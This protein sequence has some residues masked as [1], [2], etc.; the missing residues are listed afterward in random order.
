MGL[1]NSAACASV[2]RLAVLHVP[3]P[4][5]QHKPFLRESYR[6]PVIALRV[7]QHFQD[8]CRHRL[9]RHGHQA[10]IKMPPG[11]RCALSHRDWEYVEPHL[12]RTQRQ[13]APRLI[14]S[15]CAPGKR[16][17]S[18]I[19]G[20][21][22]NL[23]QRPERSTANTFASTASKC[24]VKRPAPQPASKTSLPLRVIN[25]P[26]KR[27]FSRFLKAEVPLKESS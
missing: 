21:W 20:S 18:S 25:R 14:V 17:N 27:R 16:N 10:Y 26:P 19:Y 4:H 12:H 8:A 13:T 9:V 15:V 6:M 2:C 22:H 7:L 5:C 24:P 3:P 11:F 1:V 23:P